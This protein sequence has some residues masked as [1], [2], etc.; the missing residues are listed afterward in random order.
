MGTLIDSSLWVDYFRART[1]RQVKAQVVSY[2]D[3]REAVLC[4]PVRFE[5]L[6]AALPSE[7]RQIEE[8]F[9]TLPLASTP[10]DLW[11]QSELLGQQCLAAG[12]QPLAMDLLIAQICLAHEFEIVT[13]DK[14]FGNIAKVCR[15][16]VRLLNRAV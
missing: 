12:T 6:R 4:E 11:R 15:L 16:K 14:D 5:I 2:V 3:D 13:F 10:P 7:R 9:A 8:T 1:P